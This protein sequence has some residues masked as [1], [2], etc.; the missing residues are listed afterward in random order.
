MKR[1]NNPLFFSCYNIFMQQYFINEILEINEQYPLPK[2]ILHHLKHVLRS[3][4]GERFRIVDAN[5]HL[6]LCCLKDNNA[7][8][9]EELM[10]KRELPVEVTVVMSLIKNERFDFALQKLTELGVY[11]ILPFKAQRS[12]VKIKDEEAKLER[13]RKIVTEASE[14]SLRLAVPKIPEIVDMK[15]LANYKSLGNYL[16]YEKMPD[17]HLPYG[18]LPSSITVVIGPEGGFTDDEVEKF[19][20]LGFVPV[21]LGKRILRAETAAMYVMANIAGD[22]E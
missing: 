21:A 1:M 5:R 7:M 11:Q 8:I 3:N 15:K 19:E 20:A 22:F 10:E 13:Y 12:I 4:D 14:Q 17:S 16:A 18:E 6:Y 2:E 9:L